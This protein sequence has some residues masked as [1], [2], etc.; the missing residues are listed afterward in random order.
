MN[1]HSFLRLLNRTCLVFD[2][3]DKVLVLEGP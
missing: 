1:E 2:R 3:F